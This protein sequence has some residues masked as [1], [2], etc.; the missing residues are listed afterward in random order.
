MSMTAEQR[1]QHIA[2]VVGLACE[3]NWLQSVGSHT[4]QQR[5]ALLEC[6]RDL[7]EACLRV[8]ET[9]GERR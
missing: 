6:Y 2:A 1:K 5:L 9:Y 7:V 8:A 4:M 3:Y